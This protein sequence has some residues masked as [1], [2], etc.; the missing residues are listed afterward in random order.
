VLI[1][2]ETD[3]PLA[4][5]HGEAGWAGDQLP[6]LVKP[7]F[8]GGAVSERTVREEAARALGKRAGALDVGAFRAAVE[9]G[10]VETFALVRPCAENGHEGIYAY[11]DECG[12]L[13]GLPRNERACLLAAACGFDN[14][15]F[16]G[17]VFIGRVRTQPEPMRNAHFTLLDITSDEPWLRRAAADNA[18][19]ELEMARV[20]DAIERN[21]A[22]R[23]EAQAADE[24]A[25]ADAEGATSEDD[26][27]RV[28]W[29]A[30]RADGE[31]E[32]RVPL[33]AGVRAKDL[34]VQIGASALGVALRGAEAKPQLRIGTLHAQIRADELSWELRDA[35][36]SDVGAAGARPD[37]R[38]LALT[39]VKV[40]GD[41]HWPALSARPCP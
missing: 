6:E 3:E 8:A 30:Q 28:F 21:R 12:L 34:A 31:L 33:A 20:N 29:W 5:R 14:S 22:S 16:R 37:A 9:A 23:A 39:L 10:A 15:S 35:E 38:V 26:Q 17:D 24:P 13:K 2:A 27:R 1:P 32:V 41:A 7:S 4:L 36:A 40:D 25:G 19:Y 18:A 11:M